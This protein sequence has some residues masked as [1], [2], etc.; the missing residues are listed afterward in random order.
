VSFAIRSPRHHSPRESHRPDRRLRA[1]LVLLVSAYAA[2]A[3]AAP[4]PPPGGHI[5]IHH[6]GNN[7]PGYPPLQQRLA[8]PP[9]SIRTAMLK[10]TCSPNPFNSS[11]RFSFSSGP[12]EPCRVRV[13]TLQGRQVRTIATSSRAG[14][15]RQ[16]VWDGR[17]QRGRRLP[18]GMYAFRVEAG[19]RTASG[20]V[21]YVK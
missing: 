1:L 13:F 5:L 4:P 14:G 9:P 20:K 8:V 10:V 7:R 3:W 6:G 17:D 19:G 16:V 12:E 11:T 2:I 21:I 18:P 15:V